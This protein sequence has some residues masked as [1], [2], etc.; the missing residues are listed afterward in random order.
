VPDANI[1]EEAEK[2]WLSE[3]ERV[4]ASIFEGKKL[5]KALKGSNKEV[6]AEYFN[7]EDRRVGK[8]TTVMVDGFAISK[9]SMNCGDWEAVPTMAGKDPRLAE[10]KRAKK[11]PI[12]PQSHCQVCMDGG[13]LYCCQACPRAYHRACLDKEYKAKAKSWQ[14][15]CPQ[16]HC[17]DCHQ[18]TS[19]AGGMLY[20]CRWCENAYCEDCLDF[21]K[22]EL[23][24]NTLKEYQLLGYP[25]AT[26]AFY[27]QCNRCTV[28]FEEV[29]DDEKLCSNLA[30][31]IAIDWGSKFG[32]DSREDS[33][34]DATTVETTG[35]STPV[36]EAE[37]APFGGSKKRKVTIQLTTGSVKR[38]RQE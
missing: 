25:E 23:I 9:E 1:D 3:M 32:D 5:G 33:M 2:K 20:R 31:G 26:Q 13:E 12:E 11:A 28:H 10:P 7:R 16:H 36:E 15:T 37:Y 17:F 19:D 27:I 21:D 38:E 34:T 4:E 29:P 35:V 24:G 18:S 8:E 22:T 6:A 14:F 30:A